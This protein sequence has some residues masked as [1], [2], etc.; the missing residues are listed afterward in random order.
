MSNKETKQEKRRYEPPALILLGELDNGIGYYP[1][2]D[3]SEV[4][5]NCIAGTTQAFSQCDLGV[6]ADY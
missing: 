6:G 4:E 3:G 5:P 1:C 2:T